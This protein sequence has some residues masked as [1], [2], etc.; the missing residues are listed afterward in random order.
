MKEWLIPAG[1]NDRCSNPR[2]APHYSNSYSFGTTMKG[3]MAH[4]YGFLSKCCFNEASISRFL[5]ER[6][7]AGLFPLPSP[8]RRSL[9]LFARGDEDSRYPSPSFDFSEYLLSGCSW[10]HAPSCPD[11]VG[12]LSIKLTQDCRGRGLFTS[13]NV[14]AGD[15]LLVSNPFALSY[16][17]PNSVHL[18]HMITSM[19]KQSSKALHQ[20][21]SLAGYCD[22]I[23][24]PPMEI[25]DPNVPYCDF[26]DR[27]MIKYDPHRIVNTMNTNCFGGEVRLADSEPPT[28]LNGLWLL[29]SFINHSCTPNASRLFVGKA[30]LI[31]ASTDIEANVE[32]TISYTDC[33][34][35]VH[36]RDEQLETLGCGF[37]CECQRCLLERSLQECLFDVGEPFQAMHDE[38]VDEV[39]SLVKGKKCSRPASLHACIELFKL[40]GIVSKKLESSD[41]VTFSQKQWILASYSYGFLGKCFA[42]HLSGDC[43]PSQWVNRRAVSLVESMK[44]TVPGMM[45]TL[46]FSTILAMSAKQQG[47]DAE[48]IERLHNLAMDECIRVYGKQRQEVTLKLMEQSLDAI[49]FV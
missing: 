45:R 44:C 21:A 12:P 8:R 47:S 49:P 24:V 23:I 1:S 16:N 28:P 11:F 25:F 5:F 26:T 37:F 35:P 36:M 13:A 39:F 10:K 14:R 48:L 18:Y 17:D 29:P 4:S 41:N 46:A 3:G 22:E 43:T 32:V 15:I 19:T 27:Q 30:M 33:F 6:R 2:P 31:L 9:S 40:F 42:E 34:L 7:I 20:L 38:A